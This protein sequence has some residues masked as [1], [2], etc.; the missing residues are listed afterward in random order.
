[1]SDIHADPEALHQVRERRLLLDRCDAWLFEEMAPYIGQRVLEVGCGHGN[2]ALHLLDRQVVFGI[3]VSEDS[4][5]AFRQR[6]TDQPH[7]QAQVHDITAPRVLELQRFNFDTVIALNV[8]EHIGPE[9]E[10]L[11]HIRQLLMPQGRFVVVVPAL[12]WLYGS[13]DRSIGHYR[14][15]TAK[16]LRERLEQAGFSVSFLRYYNLPGVLGWWFNGRVLRQT[17]PPTGQL[18]LFNRLVPL[19]R[20]V[21]KRFPM[22]LGLSLLATAERGVD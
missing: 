6:F 15:Y 17:V 10:A 18:R 14:R 5:S 12:P 21:E 20:A 8:L 11:H 4:I 9:A 22:P 2:L 13:M 16:M 7:V 3:D 1:M 19:V